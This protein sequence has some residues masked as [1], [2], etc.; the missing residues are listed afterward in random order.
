M[1]NYGDKGWIK[2]WRSELHNPFYNGFIHPNQPFDEFHAWIDLCLMADSDASVKTS[3]KALKIRWFWGSDRKVKHFLASVE[4]LGYAS[5]TFTP[6]KGTL[7]RIN[8][9]NSVK[10][11]TA[12]KQQ[13]AS[14]D[15]SVDA[16]EEVLLKEVGD[17]T[18]L[19]SRRTP[20]NL[21]KNKSFS[22]LNEE[23]DDEYD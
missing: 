15:A 9:G 3:L 14:V 10:D 5:V 19:E 8:K 21:K 4:A 1:A 2:L 23:L 20:Y 7:I 17:A 22:E 6:N 16:F 12:K 11:K 18:S 13:K